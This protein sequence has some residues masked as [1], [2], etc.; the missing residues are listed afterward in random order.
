MST[1]LTIIIPTKDRAEAL[2]GLL[3]SIR[4]LDQFEQLQPEIIVADNNSSDKTQSLIHACAQDFPS[5]IQILKV[6]RPGKSAAINEAINLAHGDYVAFLDDD[7]TVDRNWLKTLN[8]FFKEG[9]YQA[10]Q[11]KIGLHSPDADDPK[12][13]QL[14]SLYRTVPQLDHGPD[15][16]EVHSLNGAN[17]FMAREL[18]YRVGGFDER[19]GPGASGTSEDVDLARRLSQIG[20][21]MG[22]ARDCIVYHRIDRQRLC[23]NYFKQVHRRQGRSR[24]LMRDR[25][26]V[27]ILGDLYG[28]YWKYLYHL[29]IGNKRGRYK[30]LGRVFHY[31]EM[32]RAKRAG[33]H[34][35]P[36]KL[37]K[38]NYPAASS[39]IEALKQSQQAAEN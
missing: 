30:S 25:S 13:R 27:Y 28:S 18:L 2:A 38:L 5:Q 20:I 32:V 9:D 17:C 15:V 29:L 22:Y 31:S 8:A 33:V 37:L 7:V 12:T 16:E 26:L 3:E 36:K 19:L 35:Q 6:P 14:V 34:K 4:G 24:L 10:G 39:E 23:K 21:R 1:W 11:G